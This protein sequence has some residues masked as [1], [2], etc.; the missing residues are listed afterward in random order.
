MWRAASFVNRIKHL[1]LVQRRTVCCPTWL[2]F[3]SVT[4]LLIIPL[5]WWVLYGERFLSLTQRL[6]ADVLVVE[7]WIGTK[8]VQAAAVEFQ[9]RGYRCVVATGSQP[10]NDRGW[11]DPGWSYAQ[12]A[13]NELAR[14]GIRAD[15][16]IVAPAKDTA[17]GR[18]YES[19]VAVWRKL[20]SL[21]IHP[22]CINVFT[23]G[24]HARR[25]HLV[26]YKV[27]GPEAN[28]GVLSWTPAG[29]DSMPW[30]RSSDRARE[31][32]TETAGYFF[33]ALFNSSRNS[34][35]PTIGFMAVNR[36]ESAA[37]ILKKSWPVLILLL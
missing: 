1:R 28:V 27:F 24:P 16:I 2:G 33:E 36:E 5:A 29:Y 11:Q 3:F 21:S 9:S 22:K 18:T 31:L 20:R 8:A 19:A 14:C 15:E 35:S 32:L 37:N 34:N 23:W 25:S 12:G 17:R 6:P 10:E 26:F 7:G 30:W 4:L 13:A